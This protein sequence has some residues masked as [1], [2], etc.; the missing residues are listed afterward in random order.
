L[1][2]ISEELALLAFPRVA[3]EG[4]PVDEQDRVAGPVVLVVDLDRLVV[5]GTGE[6]IRH[7]FTPCSASR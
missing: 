2:T 5:L 1:I 3:I 7:C 6:D 4:V